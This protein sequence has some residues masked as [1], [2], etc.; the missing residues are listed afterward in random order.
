MTERSPN[1]DIPEREEGAP[2]VAPTPVR[3]LMGQEPVPARVEPL[4]PPAPKPKPLPSRTFEVEGTT[5]IAE[6]RGRTR[7]GRVPDSG[8]LILLLGFRR[9]RDQEGPDDP[10]GELPMPEKEGWL[11]VAEL[12]E[13]TEEALLECFGRSRA[14]RDAG[15]EGG[16]AKRPGPG[17][18]RLRTAGR[19]SGRGDVS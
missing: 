2:G 9:A 18:H 19:E 17:R 10:D 7:T 11:P 12:T 1:E 4:A 13:A 14:W 15:G 3:D 5:W 8:A 16:S 6:E